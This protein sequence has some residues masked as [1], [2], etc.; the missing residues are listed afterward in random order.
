ML[1]NTEFDAIVI[2]SGA[3]GGWAAKEL[4]ER[5]MRLLLLEAGREVDQIADFPPPEKA[6]HH[7]V[8]G[9]PIVNRAPRCDS[10][11]PTDSGAV[12]C[13]RKTDE[14]IFCQRS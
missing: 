3:A 7:L 13:F 6:G 9:N 11:R 1:E 10:R 5:G 8:S 12:R 4:T 14:E 2:G